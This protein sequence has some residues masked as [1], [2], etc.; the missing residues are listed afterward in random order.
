MRIC[1]YGAGAIGGFLAVR[2]TQSGEDVS[3][4]A[5][6][7]HLRAIEKSGLTLTNAAEHSV[8][9]VRAAECADQL[10]PQDCVVVTLKASAL[11]GLPHALAPLLHEGTTVAFAQN[12]IPWWYGIGL[13][14]TA[15]R[16]P[17]LTWL[18]PT[19]ALHTLRER[20]LG[21][22]I[23]SAS[24]VIAPGVVQHNSRGQSRLV[25]GEI[26]DC[27][28][29]RV[30]GLRAVLARAGIASPQPPSIR[31]AV[32]TKLMN[33]MTG[34]V[35]AALTEQP[36]RDLRKDAHF[37]A[38]LGRMRAEACSIAEAHGFALE[39]AKPRTNAATD[40]VS[41]I[42]QDYQ[43]RRPMEIDAL[44]V[45]PLAFARARQLQT[46]TLDLMGALIAHKA[47]R[48]GLYTPTCPFPI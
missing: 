30:A 38:L 24:E 7:P 9:R 12:G 8:V 18:D 39:Q 21:A 29:E 16:P 3:V 43:R 6:G 41:S 22:I 20:T 5:R 36:S 47:M 32:W 25:I 19:G 46:P 10:G 33:N 45:A 44:V 37:D 27:D 23:F 40:H 34:S 13:S 11:E 48:A 17:D 26:D 4:I 42:L 35:I 1:I 2:L 15:P 28:S 31:H 14:A